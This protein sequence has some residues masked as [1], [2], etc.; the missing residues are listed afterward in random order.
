MACV[1]MHVRIRH[2]TSLRRRAV[3]YVNENGTPL[4]SKKTD[5][6]RYAREL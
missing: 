4:D 3:R 6:T 1:Y 5:S 2:V